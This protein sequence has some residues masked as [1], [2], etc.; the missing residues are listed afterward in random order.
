[1][2][3]GLSINGLFFKEIKGISQKPPIQVV[4]R[5][6]GM[7]NVVLTDIFDFPAGSEYVVLFDYLT[8]QE[9][10]F[11]VANYVNKGAFP[12]SCDCLGHEFTLTQA[13]VYFESDLEDMG[14]LYKDIKMIISQ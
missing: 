6:R 2:S 8:R 3:T 5:V 11:L 12:V 9:Y 7:T 14:E 13:I 10:D 4:S 1:M